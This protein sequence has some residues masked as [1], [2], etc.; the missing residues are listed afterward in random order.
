LKNIEELSKKLQK[1]TVKQSIST[2]SE[3]LGTKAFDENTERW[4]KLKVLNCSQNTIISLDESL[5][6]ISNKSHNQS[7]NQTT[8]VRDT[9]TIYLIDVSFSIQFHLSAV[10]QIDLSHNLIERIENLQFCYSLEILDLSYNKISTLENA[11]ETLGNLKI[12]ILRHNKITST[13]GLEVLPFLSFFLFHDPLF[14]LFSCLFSLTK[15]N[16]FV[17]DRNFSV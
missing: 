6:H 17:C 15:N 8:F 12:L 16:T 7:I 14:L 11:V 5:V 4:K 10:Q 1:V 13:L 2:I 9:K 3:L